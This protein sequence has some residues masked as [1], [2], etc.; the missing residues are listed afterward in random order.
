M[1]NYPFMGKGATIGVTAPSSGVPSELH[2]LLNSASKSK[3]KVL[4]SLVAKLLGL[5][6]RQSLRLL[7]SEQKS[8]IE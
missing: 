6:I 3:R 8:L 7:Q 2:E 5:R 4:T 1:I